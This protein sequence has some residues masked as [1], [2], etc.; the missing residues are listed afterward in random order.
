MRSAV[1]RLAAVAASVVF[2]AIAAPV[3]AVDGV[4]FEIGKNGSYEMARIGAQWQWRQRWL[5]SGGR[6]V[7]GYWDLSAGQWRGDVPAGQNDGIADIGFT[8]TLRWQANDLRGFY[9]EGGIGAHVLSRTAMGGRRFST[10]FQ[11][12]DHLGFGYRFGTKAAYDL[13]YRFQHL[14]N[15]GIKKPNDGIDFHQIRLQYWFR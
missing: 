2:A 6:H 1:L 7:G 9:I 11:F 15:G 8:P 10:R 5:E 14:S 12:G 3:L 13:S 4:S